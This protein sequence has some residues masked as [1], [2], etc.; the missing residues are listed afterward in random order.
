[1]TSHG[2]KL[3]DSIASAKNLLKD[4]EFK[5]LNFD[6]VRDKEHDVKQPLSKLN[7]LLGRTVEKSPRPSLFHRQGVTQR[8][9][10]DTISDKLT[11][12]GEEYDNPFLRQSNQDNEMNLISQRLNDM[13]KRRLNAI[14][15]DGLELNET[16]VGQDQFGTPLWMQVL[17]EQRSTATEKLRSIDFTQGP[18]FQGDVKQFKWP[19]KLQWS[20]NHSFRQWFTSKEN[21]KATRLIEGVIDSPAEMINPLTIVGGEQSGTTFLLRATGQAMLRRQEGH[22]LWFNAL[23]LEHVSHTPIQDALHGCSTLIVDDVEQFAQHDIWKINLGEWFEYALQSS[24]Q[25]IT[26]SKQQIQELPSSKLRRFLLDGIET[27]IPPPS[28]SS[29]VQFGR[30]HARQRNMILDEEELVDLVHSS[31]KSWRS[32]RNKLEEYVHSQ[33][34]PIKKYEGI[35]PQFDKDVQSISDQIISNAIDVVHT[36]IDVGGVE[37]HSELEGFGE[38]DYE[39]PEFENIVS[40]EVPLDKIQDDTA[41]LIQKIIPTLPSL[42]NVKEEDKFIVSKDK[43]ENDEDIFTTADMLVDIDNRIEDAFGVRSTSMQDGAMLSKIGTSMEDL[44]SRIQDADIEELIS[45]ADEL[46]IIDEQL[47]SIQDRAPLQ[48]QLDSYEPEGEWFIDEHEVN[49]DELQPLPQMNAKE[50]V[51]LST[52]KKKTILQPQLSGEEE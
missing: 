9:T 5:N 3:L 18:Q 41:S 14:S 30:W 17:H 20:E 33:N 36:D 43:F 6:D 39:P 52:L 8:P 25:I 29:L 31:Q 23:D 47:Q 37:L 1:M 49:I 4:S 12:G 28:T 34:Q 21:E 15:E 40:K 45:I 42:M 35:Q 32:I 7:T 27:F 46:Q 2:H 11:G 16:I 48:S 24:I 38:D 10:Y 13:R 44:S 50:K 22:V 26:S 51:H 19:R